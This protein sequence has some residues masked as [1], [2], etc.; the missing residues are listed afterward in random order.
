MNKYIDQMV[1]YLTGVLQ[2]SATQLFIL[3]G[4]LLILALFLNLSATLNARL[5]IRFWGR[6][7]F[8]YGF[9]CQLVWVE[10]EAFFFRIS[11]E[12]ISRKCFLKR[13]WLSRKK[14]DE[15]ISPCFRTLKP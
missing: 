7:L 1:S 11:N 10:V 4:P 8:L 5:S 12:V 15:F 14:F 3:F 2:S 13:S 9:V 6:D